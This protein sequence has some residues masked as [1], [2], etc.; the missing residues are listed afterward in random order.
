MKVEWM[1]HR[2][3]NVLFLCTGNSARSIMAE[4]L[5]NKLGEGRFKGFSAGSHPKGEINQFALHEL[6][7]LGVATNGLSSK[8]WTVFATAGAPH[9]DFIVTV[10]DN[11]AG[12]TCPVWP[13]HP[14]TAHWGIED[15]AIV[16]GTD[17]D[18]QR[19]FAMAAHDLR[20]RIAAFISLPITSLDKLALQE[21]L[22]EIDRI[23]GKFGGVR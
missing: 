3:F 13:G 4:A 14:A 15:P 6:S 22:R 18:K 2:V 17:I 1:P 21:R 5:L 10:C 12:E 9:M 7:R 16:K 23:E 19:A 20:D 11:V 8:S